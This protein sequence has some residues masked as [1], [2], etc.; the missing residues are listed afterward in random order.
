MYSKPPKELDEIRQRMIRNAMPEGSDT[1]RQIEG[2][3]RIVSAIARTLVP[4]FGNV[5]TQ[6]TLNRARYLS[7]SRYPILEK[8]PFTNTGIDVQLLQR[9][10]GTE[11]PEVARETFIHFVDEW[12][13]A[14][15]SLLDG[16]LTT[17]LQEAELRLANNRAAPD[18][19][20]EVR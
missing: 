6:A 7:Q 2:L 19:E 17:L 18:P 15:Y 20:E 5:A 12:I 8:L 16:I 14:L 9:E 11:S 1:K 3:A 13:D 10:M 4:L